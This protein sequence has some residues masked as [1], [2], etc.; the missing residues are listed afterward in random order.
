MTLFLQDVPKNRLAA[1]LDNGP[2]AHGGL[3]GDEHSQSACEG[4]RFHGLDKRTSTKNQSA[5]NAEGDGAENVDY[6]LRLIRHGTAKPEPWRAVSHGT[7]GENY[8]PTNST[9]SSYCR[10]TTLNQQRNPC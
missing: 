10:H 8:Q 2:G 6:I 5:A 4:E 7:N 1:D 3:L 9:N